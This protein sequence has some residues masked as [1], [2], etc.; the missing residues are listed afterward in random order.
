MPHVKM[1][2]FLRRL[3]RRRHYSRTN[4]DGTM[5]LIDHLQELPLIVAL[6][7]EKFFGVGA[8][9]AIGNVLGRIFVSGAAVGLGAGDRAAQFLLPRFKPLLESF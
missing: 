4:P 8:G 2:D 5:S 9:R 1:P 7:E 6:A 3:D